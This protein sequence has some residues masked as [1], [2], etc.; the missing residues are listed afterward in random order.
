MIEPQ[1]PGA[2]E[3]LV[4]LNDCWDEEALQKDRANIIGLWRQNA[5]CH[6]R[7][8]R[9]LAAACS[10]LGDSYRIAAEFVDTGKIARY[11]ARV[12]RKEFGAQ[13][14][15]R[16]KESIRFLSAVTAQGVTAFTDTP[17]ALCNRIYLVEDDCGAVSRLLLNA[18][19]AHALEAG[20]DIISCYCVTSPFEKL[21]HVLIPALGVGFLTSNRYHPFD[22]ECYRRIHAKR[23]Q[24]MVALGTK[25]QR[26]SFNRK[27]VAELLG[28]ASRLMAE[29]KVFHDELET[30]YT[31]HM[32]FD[33]VNEKTGSVISSFLRLCGRNR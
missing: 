23:F 33:K 13:K 15:E 12:A 16:G 14:G 21:E 20:L 1:Y 6:E 18:M 22:I 29:A 32:D 27:A 9:F 5:R 17:Q 19:R 3:S 7:C 2:F 31:L 11:A 30:Y 8:C 25:R 4:T 10:L 26:L 24:D 28:E